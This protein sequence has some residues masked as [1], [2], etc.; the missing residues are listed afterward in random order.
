MPK[1]LLF[2]VDSPKKVHRAHHPFL[3]E[4]QA[5]LLKSYVE[6]AHSLALTLL[7][8]LESHLGLP[9]GSFTS[10]HRLT[11]PSEDHVRLLRAPPQPPQDLRTALGKHTDFGS[12]TIL[13]NRIGGLQILP[14]PS[15]TDPSYVPEWTY[16]RPLPGHCVVNLGDA[17]TKFSGGILRSNIHRVVAPPGEQM[18]WPKYSLVYFMRPEDEAPMKC[19]MPGGDGD[20]E[21]I[22]CEEWIKLQY[23]R[24]D[25]S[26]QITVEDRQRLWKVSGRAELV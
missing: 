5:P 6:D 21:E 17:M 16:V 24:V 2:G 25:A 8:Y 23:R 19:L 18:N 1:D 26:K 9:A 15:K 11:A 4:T 14:P 3:Q 12:V 22:S 10:L 20:Q 7:G 13:F